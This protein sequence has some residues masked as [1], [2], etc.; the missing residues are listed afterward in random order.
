MFTSVT[1]NSFMGNI[2]A[3]VN[4]M[5]GELQINPAIWNDLPSDYKEFILLHEEGHLKL[6]TPSEYEA[7]RYAIE[8]YAAVGS[9]TDAEGARRITVLAEIFNPDKTKAFGQ[10]YDNFTGAAA[11][12]IVSAIG[13]VFQVL[14]LIGVG[15]KGRIEETTATANAQIAIN[16]QK[17]KSQ[18]IIIL[19]IGGLVLSMLAIYYAFK[20]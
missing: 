5:T 10:K 13:S 14:P 4:R 16:E 2:P 3:R 8:N 11:G 15:K 9:L 12:A 20:K 6:N 1:Y 19:T 17:S 7:N 18:L